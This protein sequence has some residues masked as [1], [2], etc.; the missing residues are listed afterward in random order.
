MPKKRPPKEVWA[1]LREIVW[2]RD[3]KRCTRCKIAQ[4]LKEC[5][6]DHIVSGKNGTNSISNLR[7][8]CRTCHT[9]RA[10]LRH[11][12]MRGNAL[13]KGIIKVGWRNNVWED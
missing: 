8:L 1:T 6:I 13:K 3:G 2:Y 10:D 11:N 9:L 4:T 7:T 5:H 12:G